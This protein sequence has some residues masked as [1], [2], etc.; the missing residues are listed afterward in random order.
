MKKNTVFVV[1][2]LL[3]AVFNLNSTVNKIYFHQSS[4]KTQISELTV[5]DI[6]TSKARIS[7]TICG[8]GITEIGVCYGSSEKPTVAGEKKVTNYE[9]DAYDVP[10]KVQYKTRISKLEQGK[11][12]YARAYV[13]NK[14]GKIF[15][16]DDIQ[17]ATEK[18]DDDFTALLNGP[19][20]EF[21]PN[22]VIKREY[23]MK[24]GKVDGNYRSYDEEGKIISDEIIK[25][26]ITNGLCKY[27][28]KNGQVKSEINLKNGI[29]DGLG[30]EYYENG[31]IKTISSITGH[32][33]ELSGEIKQ[34]TEEKLL[35]SE[36]VISKGK[37]SSSINYDSKGRVT[38]EEKD[39]SYTSYSYDN[40]GWRHISENGNKCTCGRCKN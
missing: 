24:D 22:G 26:G 33:Q 5:S 13:K 3:I 10:I 12:Y 27:F 32:P 14:A 37:I 29:Q 4:V 6:S 8:M 11:V 40:D 28:Y 1:T 18:K 16:S 17:F 9:G 38:N 39:G 19:K 34:F 36:T 20:K 21:Y 15:Y 2:L 25:D 35:K 30:K 7:F 23:T 31:Y